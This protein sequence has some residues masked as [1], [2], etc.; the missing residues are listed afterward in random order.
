MIAFDANDEEQLKRIESEI[1]IVEHLDHENIVKYY[2]HAIAFAEG[3]RGSHN[4]YIIMEY[5]EGGSL[6]NLTRK[7]EEHM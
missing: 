4:V 7:V 2:G 3:G 6:L 5:C 1:D